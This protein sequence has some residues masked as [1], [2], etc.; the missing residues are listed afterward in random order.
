MKLWYELRLS[1]LDGMYDMMMRL[2]DWLQER[3]DEVCSK[4]RRAAGQAEA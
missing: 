1:V 3:R 2:L 4:W